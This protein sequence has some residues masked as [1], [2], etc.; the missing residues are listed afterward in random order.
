MKLQ[1]LQ[2]VIRAIIQASTKPVTFAELMLAFTQEEK[3]TEEQIWKALKILL[4]VDDPVQELKEIAGGYRY[5]IKSQYASWIQRSQGIEEPVEKITRITNEPLAII[6]YKQPISRQ[7]IDLIRGASTHL[8]VLQ[9][10]EERGWIK[11]VAYGGKKNRAALYGTTSKFLEYFSLN[12]IYDLPDL[13]I[14]TEQSI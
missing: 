8:S 6:A 5:Q 2:H 13:K 7:E 1:E 4:A 14:E 12:S 9:Q 10:L 11:I 3:V